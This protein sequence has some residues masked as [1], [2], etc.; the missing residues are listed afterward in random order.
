MDSYGTGA[1]I[2]N[3]HTLASI[4]IC[5]CVI[6]GPTLFVVVD[7][8][9]NKHLNLRIYQKSNEFKNQTELP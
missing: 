6:K 8:Y 5:I 1:E 4:R 7:I 9:G 2:K 3:T